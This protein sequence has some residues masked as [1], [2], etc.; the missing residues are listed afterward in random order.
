MA[1]YNDGDNGVYKHNGDKEKTMA[2]LHTKYSKTNISAGGFLMGETEYW[3]EFMTHDNKTGKPLKAS[4]RI[5][6]NES[7]DDIVKKYNAK[8]IEV[9][10]EATAFLSFP[11]KL[12][13]IKNKKTI[14]PDGTHTGR[15]L[16]GKYATAESAGNY[17][18]GLNGASGTTAI[19]FPISRNFYMFLAGMLHSSQNSSAVTNMYFGE[20]PYVGRRI[21]AGFRDGRKNLHLPLGIPASNK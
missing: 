20:I 2:E 18:A 21:D 15:L 16:N 6:F 3:D 9:G 4:G 1:V 11:N 12:F 8:S 7:W 19:G 14:S 13:D 5:R 10:L 17:L